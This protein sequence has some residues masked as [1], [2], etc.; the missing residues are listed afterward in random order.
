MQPTA[1]INYTIK[2]CS[3]CCTVFLFPCKKDLH[4]KKNTFMIKL[5]KY[6]LIEG[7]S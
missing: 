7:F 6:E 2:R 4:Y 3:N 5:V 1:E